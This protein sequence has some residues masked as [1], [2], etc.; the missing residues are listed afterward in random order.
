MVKYWDLL[1]T[2]NLQGWVDSGYIRIQTHPE[3]DNLKIASYTEKAVFDRVWTGTTKNSRGLIF[4][5]DTGDVVARPF[6]K[7]F[8]YGEPMAPT[9]DLETEVWATDKMDGSLG[10]VYPAPDGS[11]RVATRGSF[12]SD[13]AIHATH[14][15]DEK[16]SDWVRVWKHSP[17]STVTP[18][19]EIVYPENR[20]VCDYG[21]T[22]DL[23]LLGWIEVETGTYIPP[24][25]GDWDGPRTESF[26]YRNLSQ[27]L[28]ASSRPGAEGMVL[29][30]PE[31]HDWV[32]V[33]QEDYLELHRIVTELSARRVYE[34]LRGGK[35][36][37][38]ICSPLP[39]EFHQFVRDVAMV[40][41]EKVAYRMDASNRAHDYIMNCVTRKGVT[42]KEFRKEYALFA[43]DDQYPSL[44]FALLDGQDI[45]DRVWGLF[46]PSWEWVPSNHES[47][48]RKE[49]WS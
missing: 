35:T 43:K 7:F 21:E 33:K 4:D 19:V 12:A 23:V 13:Q 47:Y 44:L 40:I 8:N 2:K 38:E 26:D 29:Y 9:L 22:D 36:V 14:V 3:F 16:Y 46:E 20:I 11:V 5:T 32:K 30:I 27:A 34:A 6:P 39:D 48:M 42:G 18:L 10:I 25:Y 45:T 1:E 17:G 49:G 28:S 15:L 41:R 31:I 24:G 37:E